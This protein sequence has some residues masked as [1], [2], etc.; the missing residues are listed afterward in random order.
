MAFYQVPQ[1]RTGGFTQLHDSNDPSAQAYAR[2][3][4]ARNGIHVPPGADAAAMWRQFSQQ[5][6]SGR[7]GAMAQGPDPYDTGVNPNMPLGGPQPL[8][9]AAPGSGPVAGPPGPDMP[10]PGPGTF[11]PGAGAPGLPQI[12]PRQIGAQLPGGGFRHGMEGQG[13][14]SMLDWIHREAA[15]SNGNWRER[16]QQMAAALNPANTI[17][18]AAN[19]MS[20]EFHH[21]MDGPAAA[22]IKLDHVANAQRR[23]AALTRSMSAKRPSRAIP[24]RSSRSTPQ[25]Y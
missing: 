22:A 2:Q 10:M 23:V 18:R 24:H 12:G 15:L 13:S 9:P 25:A 14:G 20:G 1:G 3:A 8:P 6:A 5:R 19:N 21:V 4:L 7:A 11:N 16:I 17:H